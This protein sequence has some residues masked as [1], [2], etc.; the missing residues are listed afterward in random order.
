M[1]MR[2][3]AP[4]P[5]ARRTVKSLALIDTTFPSG[6]IRREGV[7]AGAGWLLAGSARD[8]QSSVPWRRYGDSRTRRLSR[9]D[10]GDETDTS[11]YHDPQ[12]R[13]ISTAAYIRNMSVLT[14][15]LDATAP[16]AATASR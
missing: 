8:E 16:K 7:V 13:G 6:H 11:P 15:A 9:S 1:R 12:I 10:V 5:G 14:H 3:V 2:S 4:A